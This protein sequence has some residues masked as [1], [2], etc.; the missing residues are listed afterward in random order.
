MFI[1]Q[2]RILGPI[3]PCVSMSNVQK[4]S[5]KYNTIIESGTQGSL[6]FQT[7]VSVTF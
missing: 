4:Q 1:A 2:K 5:P 6:G 3:V 7:L